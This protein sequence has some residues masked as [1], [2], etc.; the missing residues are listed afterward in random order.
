MG[1]GRVDIGA[2]AAFRRALVVITAFPVPARIR[3]DRDLIGT[4]VGGPALATAVGAV[5]VTTLTPGLLPFVYP[6][7]RAARDREPRAVAPPVP[8]LQKESMP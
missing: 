8:L 1:D 5:L 6:R 3:T 2:V 4:P 7:R